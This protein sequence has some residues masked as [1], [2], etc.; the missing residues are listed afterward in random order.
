VSPPAFRFRFPRCTRLRL[1]DYTCYFDLQNKPQPSDN[2]GVA[3]SL[4][5]DGI[6][7]QQDN[8]SFGISYL[9]ALLF[10]KK[11][12]DFPR[13]ARKAVRV[14]QYKGENRLQLLKENEGP[15]GYAAG[16][17]GLLSFI[18]ALLPSREEIV[19]GIRETISTLPML[20]IREVVANAL[21]HQ[22]LS[23][24]GTGPTVEMFSNRIEVTNPG[25]PL[26]DVH[27]IVD[28]PPK[29]R[30]ER[31]AS[32]LRRLGICEELGTAPI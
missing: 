27:R 1:L 8:G 32:L 19:G 21:I 26:I 6:L 7:V 23:V 16:F 29:S 11:L 2:T 31:T 28:N 5:E 14:V 9:G 10:A 15:K 17:A 24:S 25:S 12:S 20:A 30:N 22:D 18:E 3:F 13:I 4:V